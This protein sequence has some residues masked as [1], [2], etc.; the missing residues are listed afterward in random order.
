MINRMFK[1]ATLKLTLYYILVVMLISLIFSVVVY[2]VGTDNLRLALH[3]QTNKL[4]IEY[5]FFSQHSGLQ[6]SRD[7]L[8]ASN[9]DLLDH[10]ILTNLAVLIGAGFIGYVLAKQTLKPIEQSHQQQQRF[11]ADVSHELRTPLTAIKMESEV[12]LLDK[13]LTA[14]QL[15]EVIASNI[16]EA[17]KL[18]GLVNNLL[19]LTRLEA[20][21]LQ[22]QFIDVDLS[23]VISQAIEHVQSR[24]TAKQIDINTEMMPVTVK[25]DKDSLEQMFVIFLDNAIK[26]SRKKSVITLSLASTSKEATVT[27]KDNGVGIPYKDI[28]H[29]FDRFYRSDHSRSGSNGYGLGLSIAKLIA[30][31]HQVTITISSQEGVGTSVITSFPLAQT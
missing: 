23:N 11:T 2:K 10:L 13:Q 3:R 8:S 7:D 5:P 1:S 29:I 30:D 31:V 24:A 19:R 16:E 15:R 25:G 12:A 22:Q 27:V 6:Y 18:D 26:Y 28:E 14:K 20:G 17:A 9:H 21:E 4:S